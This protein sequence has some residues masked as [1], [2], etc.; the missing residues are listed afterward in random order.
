MN[1]IYLS[2]MLTIFFA[3]S[4]RSQTCYGKHSDNMIL[5]T[6]QGGVEF[7]YRINH[8][9]NGD[10]V[11]LQI[12]NT[13]AGNV[14]VTMTPKVFSTNQVWQSA[15]AQVIQIPAQSTLNGPG[16]CS[17]TGSALELKG[18]EL[19]ANEVHPEYNFYPSILSFELNNININ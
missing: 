12:T 5:L 3:L 7:Y 16:A 2:C 8:C 11:L 18:A 4:G 19:F 14:T 6:T 1:T 13:T 10:E 15:T 17:I 9:P